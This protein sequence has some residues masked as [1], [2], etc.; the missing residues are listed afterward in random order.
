MGSMSCP[1]VRDLAR[2]TGLR[3]A[4]FPQADATD[5]FEG[6]LRDPRIEV[7]DIT[8]HPSFASI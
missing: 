3:D 1:S 2:A 5:D 8:T 6:Q 7:P 4:F